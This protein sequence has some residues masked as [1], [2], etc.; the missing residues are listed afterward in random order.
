MP[1]IEY[2]LMAQVESSLWWYKVL[3]QH[4]CRA[5]SDLS[6]PLDAYILDLGCGTGGLLQ[7]L[8]KAHY[9]NAFGQDINET[10]LTICSEQ[11]LNVSYGD[12]GAL[13]STRS[14]L[15]DVIVSNDVIIAFASTFHQAIIEEMS[16]ILK[17][18][19]ILI[20]NLPARQVFRGSHDLAVGIVERINASEFRA[21]LE[22]SGFSVKSTFAWPFI[23]A[24]LILLIRS[25]QRLFL[26]LKP[27]QSV[28]SD[29]KPISPFFNCIFEF[30]T[31]LEN[32]LPYSLRQFGSSQF[33]VC[34]KLN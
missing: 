12:I 4:V 7:E 16:R 18:G 11:G 22:S 30:I 15:A 2:R 6:V 29:V 8:K 32:N 21:L 24:P 10:A 19:G 3:H 20:F 31:K 34:K 27:S 25:I 26:V 33:F 23:L 17:S 28:N 5:L 9:T 1:E 13:S 14:N